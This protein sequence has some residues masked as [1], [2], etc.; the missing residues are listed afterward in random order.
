M[1]NPYHPPQRPSPSLAQ[2]TKLA[3]ED[4]RW[5]EADEGRWRNR[6]FAFGITV[7]C[8]Y[9]P[10]SWLLFIS[11]S[12][13]SYRMTW[14]MLWPILPGLI[15]GLPFHPR[16][17]VEFPVMALAT[18]ILVVFLTYIGSKGIVGR[19]ASAAIALAISVPTAMLAYTLFR[20]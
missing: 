7:L 15:A 20:A 10:F 2:R 11:Y 5:L 19:I 6:L 16:S 1:A 14:L 3:A 8:L 9:G 17:S 13:N 12:W 18:L 4:E